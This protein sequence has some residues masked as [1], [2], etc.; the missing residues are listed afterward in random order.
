[1]AKVPMP[2]T[3]VLRC[4]LSTLR[5][6][7]IQVQ[8]HRMPCTTR[9]IVRSIVQ[10]LLAT[11]LSAPVVAQR[12]PEAA[13]ITGGLFTYV[14]QKGDSLTLV[15]ARFSAQA[16]TRVQHTTFFDQPFRRAAEPCPAP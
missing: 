10:L 5:S 6:H 13:G 9:W 3:P 14:V 7:S 15:G 8:R 4:G 11:L 16:P 2:K 12:P 1:M